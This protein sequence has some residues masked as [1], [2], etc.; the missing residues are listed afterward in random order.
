MRNQR[1]GKQARKRGTVAPRAGAASSN[2]LLSLSAVS[3]DSSPFL[4]GVVALAACAPA[5]SPAPAPP[6]APLAAAESSYQ[7]VRTLKDA[8][9]VA[10]ARGA[11][12]VE[13]GESLA[14]VMR[15]YAPARDGLAALLGAADSA[16]LDT[17]D[18]RALRTMRLTLA[19]ELAS[20][21]ATTE[22]SAVAPPDCRYDAAAIAA[23]PGGLD[24]LRA[25]LYACYGWAAMHVTVGGEQL[26][27]LTVLGRLTDTPDS[28]ER[29]RLFLA[30]TP[31]FASVNGDDGPSSPY[32][33]MIRLSAEQWRAHGSPVAEAAQQA[34]IAPDS[35]A[36]WLEQLLA[37]WRD[38][39]AD[40]EVEPW[41]YD[42]L[43]G[44]AD[45]R[46]DQAVAAKGL[47]ALNAAYYR[48]LG[49]DVDSLRVRY[50]LAPREGKTPVAYTTFG[51]RA[52]LAAGGWIPGDEWV[53]ATYRY[54]GLGNL[55]ELMH[56]TGHGI[57][58]AAIR[59]RPA[60][61]D[62]PDD[63]AFTEGIADVA[64]LEVYEPAWQQRWLGD[65]ATL[66]EG[67]RARYSA[68]MLD[69]CWALFEIRMHADPG[70]DPNAVWTR[71]THDYLRIRAHPELSWWARR[72]QLVDQPGYMSNYAIGAILIADIRAA[73]IAARGD[74]A[75]GDG[76][77][78]A[79]MSARLYR[80]GL[81][82]SSR[83]VIAE[84]LG[85]APSPRALLDDLGRMRAT[86]R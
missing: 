9:D 84:F 70:A 41:D 47:A 45:R 13:T 53:F 76:G 38:V 74:F 7:E 78:Y 79:W 64:A 54:A 51:R 21:S 22:P 68:I 72:G 82:K 37:R 62:W 29:R 46:L 33:V 10:R 77:W 12:R 81:A 49:A 58:I 15:A 40:S 39:T 18:R 42:Y 65:S 20:D 2:A 59:A 1:P 66:A 3:R 43:A 5:P 60:F 67:L 85:R 27:R 73:I 80:Y 28:A 32:R 57:H 35:V 17:V 75:A 23:L 44:R 26:D 31:L 71:L 36:P 48:A 56:E 25:R 16:S 8:M 52:R 86:R 24:S 14:A 69:V 4:L 50:D 83:A 63:D 61:L 11:M 55:N 19:N 34:G 6:R 30:L